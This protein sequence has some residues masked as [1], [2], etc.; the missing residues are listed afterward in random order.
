M[1]SQPPFQKI[2]AAS[3]GS[4]RVTILVMSHLRWGFVFQRP[5]HVLTRLARHCDILFVEEPVFDPGDPRLD[6]AAVS[7][8]VEVVTPRLPDPATGFADSHFAPLGRMLDRLLAERRIRE[9]LV[10]FYTPMALPVLK[11]LEPR[12]IVYD[13]MDDLAS[14]RFAPPEL[15]ARE[16]RLLD[17]ADVVLT[18]GPSLQAARRKRRPDARCLPSAVDV[19]HY[20]RSRLDKRSSE[21]TLAR[22][23]HRNIP[24]PRLGYMGVIDERIDLQLLQDLADNRPDWSLVMVGPIVKID[25]AS[26]PRRRNIHW[27]GMQSYSLL[28]HLLPHWDVAL[29]P[30]ALNEATR[31]ISPTKTL[32]YL[33]GGLD[34][35]STAVPD[36]ISLYGE[37]VKIAPGAVDFEKAIESL[38]KQS[39]ST[40]ENVDRERQLVLEYSTWD[41]M[42]AKALAAIRPWLGES[43][44]SIPDRRLDAIGLDDPAPSAA[45]RSR[46]AAH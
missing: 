21:A 22:T 31:F 46:S 7:P 28:P 27:L 13:C 32:E 35:V 26:V 30:F 23:L 12:G 25:P 14:F 33:A 37:V 29:M 43:T 20:A 36:V 15:L 24:G 41:A 42:V 18:G 38:W 9:P 44:G 45:S 6:I 11:Y 1:S 4:G 3:P 5:Q 40:R 19:D 16:G 10:W 8:G 2:P 34:V 17:I 39:R